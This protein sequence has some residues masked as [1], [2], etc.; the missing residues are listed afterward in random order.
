[1]QENNLLF[2]VF[3]FFGK[4]SF[5]IRLSS[6]HL[7]KE[8]GLISVGT[9]RKSIVK[10]SRKVLIF[11]YYNITGAKARDKE[12]LQWKERRSGCRQ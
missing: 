8:H 3:F 5:D 10:Y 4:K 12:F 1:M 2:F 11:A 6:N 7:I 9:I